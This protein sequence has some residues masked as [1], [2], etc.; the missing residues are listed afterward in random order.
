[1]VDAPAGGWLIGRETELELLADF[2]SG[3][4]PAHTLLFTGAPGIG[5]T[6]LWEAGLGLAGQYGFRVLVARPC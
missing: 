1:M 4:P 6:A 3:D 5:K 2:V